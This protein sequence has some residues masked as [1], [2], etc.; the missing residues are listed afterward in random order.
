M[1]IQKDVRLCKPIKNFKKVENR[2]GDP[3]YLQTFCNDKLLR[4]RDDAFG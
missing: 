1:T 4:I 2:N 3:I